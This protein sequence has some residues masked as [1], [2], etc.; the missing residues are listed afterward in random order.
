MQMG[1][2]HAQICVHRA[3]WPPSREETSATEDD[4]GLDK[5]GCRA[6]E[7]WRGVKINPAAERT[8]LPGDSTGR[9]RNNQGSRKSSDLECQHLGGWDTIYWK[10]QG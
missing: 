7:M 9:F 6:D 8:G 5:G 3:I 2:Y 10:G 1:E 4:A